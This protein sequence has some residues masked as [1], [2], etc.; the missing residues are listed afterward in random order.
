MLAHIH[1]YQLWFTAGLGP[2]LMARFTRLR[3][4]NRPRPAKCPELLCSQ[5]ALPLAAWC[6]APHQRALLLLLSSYALMRQTKTLPP[7][8]VV[9][10]TAGLCRLLPVPAGKWP[11]PAL[12]LQSLYRCLDP[13]PAVFLRCTCS[14]LPEEHRPHIR[15]EMFGTSGLPLQCNFSKARYFGGVRVGWRLPWL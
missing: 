7:T 2:Y 14:F 1:P 10:I 9:P 15:S 11:F 3:V 12:S 13:Y 5:Q 8:S 4:R 6:L